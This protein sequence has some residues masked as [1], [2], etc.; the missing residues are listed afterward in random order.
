MVYGAH[1]ALAR[2]HECNSRRHVLCSHPVARWS[3]RKPGEGRRRR[4]RKRAESR[5]GSPPQVTSCTT[6]VRKPRARPA[7]QRRRLQRLR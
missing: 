7:L 6:I 4:L 3:Q 2:R 5:T 1:G